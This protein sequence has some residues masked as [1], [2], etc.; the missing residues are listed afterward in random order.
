MRVSEI[1]AAAKSLISNPAEWCQH[2]NQKTTPN[3]I[4][5][6]SQGALQQVFADLRTFSPSLGYACTQQLA[7]AAADLMY[8][9]FSP[10]RPTAFSNLH[11]HLN[12]NSPHHIV[13]Q[14]WDRAIALARDAEEQSARAEPIPFPARRESSIP[15]SIPLPNIPFSK[16]S[17]AAL[18]EARKMWRELEQLQ[19]PAVTIQAPK[20]TEA[21]RE[22]MATTS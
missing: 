15:V 10:F 20:L 3:G 12:D 9:Q 18:D 5:V 21:E 2:T 17:D 8:Y 6:C 7:L 1:L 16:P 22:C 14:M 4:Q 13:M 19:P 11:I